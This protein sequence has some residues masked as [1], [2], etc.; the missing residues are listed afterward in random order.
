M[1]L[2]QILHKKI[3]EE[4]F[5]A[6]SLGNQSIFTLATWINDIFYLIDYIRWKLIGEVFG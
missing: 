4:Y 6:E 5:K 1:L 3:L 2:K